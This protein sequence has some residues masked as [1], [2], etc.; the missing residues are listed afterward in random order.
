M[1]TDIKGLYNFW[2][3][4]VTKKKILTYTP[5]LTT[6]EIHK[7]SA[8]PRLEN[9]LTHDIKP[10]ENS[11]KSSGDLA[12]ISILAGTVLAFSSTVTLI[13]KALNL[14]KSAAKIAEQRQQQKPESVIASTISDNQQSVIAAY[15][16]QAHTFLRKGDISRAIALFDNAIRVFPEDAYLYSQRA[17]LRRQNLQDPN[18]ALEDYTKAINLH[19]DN[20]LFYFWRSQL[21]YESSDKYKAMADYNTAIRLAPEDTMYHSLENR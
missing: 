12:L 13:C 10:F 20:P 7:P 14:N 15:V 1:I 18:G 17:N 5:L 19:P 21:Y 4:E 8:T 11:T 6:K 16:K 3:N 2:G 9:S